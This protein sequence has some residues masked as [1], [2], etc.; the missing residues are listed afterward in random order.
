MISESDEP[1]FDRSSERLAWCAI[2]IGFAVRFATLNVHG[3]SMDEATDYEIAQSSRALLAEGDGFPPLY[4]FVERSMLRQGAGVTAIRAA[5]AAFGGLAVLWSW[6]LARRWFSAT[7]AG[8]AARATGMRAAALA[9][10]LLA[11]HPMLVTQAR[12]MRGYSLYLLLTVIAV[13][14]LLAAIE[15]DRWSHW[16]QF[17]AAGVLA[18]YTHYYAG[19]LLLLLVLALVF[20]TAFSSQRD[21]LLSKRAVGTAALSAFA[22][23]PLLQALGSDLAH[24]TGYESHY[25]VETDVLA[26]GYAFVSL[27]IGPHLGPSPRQLHTLE[28]REALVGFGPGLV[29]L[30]YVLVAGAFWLCR[31]LARGENSKRRLASRLLPILAFAV[32]PPLL[33]ALAAR[34]TGV[35]YKPSYVVWASVAWAMALGLALALGLQPETKQRRTSQLPGSALAV[36]TTVLLIALAIIGLLRRDLDPHHRTEDIRAV[37]AEIEERERAMTGSKLDAARGLIPGLVPV[38]VNADYMVTPLAFYRPLPPPIALPT[39]PCSDSASDETIEKALAE[40]RRRIDRAL[41]AH[42]VAWYVESRTFHGDPCGHTARLLANEYRL[43]K[44]LRF[45]GAALY[46]LS[47]IPRLESGGLEP[48]EQ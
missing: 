48:G 13:E 41:S 34:T 39:V 18:L 1:T 47:A 38:V 42:D 27:I 7:G 5:S 44:P 35:T 4:A 14:R 32:F 43:G 26:I 45:A 16:L 10:L 33:A 22:C 23:L 12:E 37:A 19:F 9:T 28:A 8:A 2:G 30:T 25:V 21:R 46:E 6:L 40:N 29:A 3:L 31:E 11:L 20:A 15:T 24:Q 17:G 36:L